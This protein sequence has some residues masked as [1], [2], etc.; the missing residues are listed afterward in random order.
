MKALMPCASPFAAVLML[1]AVV[2]RSAAAAD[3]SPPAGLGVTITV[4]ARD[5]SVQSK[6]GARFV[7]DGQGDQEEISSAIRALPAAGGTVLLAEGT[8]DIRRV[9][10]TLG[11][12]II[13]R[14]CVTLAGQGAATRLVLASDQ[15]VNVIRIIG[16]GVGH[17]T[18]RDLCVDAN[19]GQNREGAGDPN[20]SHDRFEFCGIKAF[21]QAPRGPGAA[22]DTHDITVRN[23][24]VRDAHRLGI[25]LEGPNMRVLD[26]VLGNAGSDSVEILTGPGVIRG[27]IVEITG[28]THVAIG[29]DRANSIVMADNIVRVKQG[30]ALDIGFR[31]WA[32]SKRHVIANNVLTVED[33]GSCG[34]AMDIRGTETTITGNN[35]HTFDPAKPTRLRIA[36]GN[37]IVS[38]NVLENAVVE[39]D[40]QTGANQPIMLEANLLQN[41]EIVLRKGKVLRPAPMGDR[42]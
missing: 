17:V 31:S 23:C 2:T 33:G 6:V 9:A 27:N 13:D 15:N 16:S 22:E 7:A 30:G 26:N 20:I 8:Y 1:A 21:R 39:V 3:S 29:S 34:L 32:G 25:M 10:G 40:D 12:V 19:R 24:M 42:K 5:S 37:A 38:A 11:G 28:Q 14:S 18:I 4:A 35:M 36:A 41:S